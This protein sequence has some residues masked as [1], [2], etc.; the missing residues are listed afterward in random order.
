M[1]AE[2]TTQRPSPNGATQA[3]ARAVATSVDEVPFRIEELFFSRTDARGRI[4][5]GNDVFQRVS[6]YSWEEMTDRPHNIVRHPDM[7]RA[8][9]FLLWERIRAGLPVGAYVKNRSKDGRH[10]WVYAV[11]T[12]VEDGYLSVRL[13][14]TSALFAAAS[15]LYAAIRAQ[16]NESDCKPADSA[17]R[18]AIWAALA[19][20]AGFAFPPALEEQP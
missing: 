11:V 9:F 12:P 7:P 6:Q 8:V 4:L 2:D 19:Q 20:R 5:S 16:E 13:K 1:T 14:P 18:L 3:G 17:Q 10:Y 15:G